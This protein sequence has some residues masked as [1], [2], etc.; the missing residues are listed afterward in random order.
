MIHCRASKNCVAA[1]QAAKCL[2]VISLGV[3]LS[4]SLA[5]RSFTPPIPYGTPSGVASLASRPEERRSR[6]VSNALRA[7]SVRDHRCFQPRTKKEGLPSDPSMVRVSGALP[8]SGLEEC[9]IGGIPTLLEMA[10]G[11][12]EGGTMSLQDCVQESTLVTLLCALGMVKFVPSVARLSCLALPGS[13]LNVL[14]ADK[15]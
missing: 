13:S 4:D 15:S 5:A 12:M 14:S 10:L 7:S 6:R 11:R 8:S 3:L 9:S 1:V 2:E